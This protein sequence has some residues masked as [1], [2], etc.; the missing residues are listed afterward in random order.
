M[1][2]FFVLDFDRC[3]GNTNGIQQLLEEVII[4]E[5]GVATSSF[6][7]ARRAMESGGKTFTTI[8][9]IHELIRQS[10]SEKTWDDLRNALIERSHGVDLLLPHARDFL[11]RLNKENLSYGIITYGVEEA[12]QLTKLEIAGLLDVPHLVTHIETKS[13]LLQ[14]WKQRDGSFIVPPALL[15]DFQ[16]MT[17]Q[18]I[19][20]VDDKARSFWGMPDGVHGIH[21][22][23]PGGNTLPSQQGE[24]PPGVTQVTGMDG[25]LELLFS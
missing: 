20:L 3:L 1:K 9:H 19:V 12:W 21:V 23:A 8:Q 22:I 16:P 5:L 13:E 24:V 7:E 17:V 15:K 4:A 2:T 10:G 6:Q 14:G 25:A 11:A 18:E